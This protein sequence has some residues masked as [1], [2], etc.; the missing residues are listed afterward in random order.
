MD[1]DNTIWVKTIDSIC[2]LEIEGGA[3]VS[4]DLEHIHCFKLATPAPFTINDY[5]MSMKVWL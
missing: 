2:H 3:S 4:N 5:S 1:Y